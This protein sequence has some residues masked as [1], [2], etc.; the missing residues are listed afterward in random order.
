MIKYMHTLDGKPAMFDGEQIVTGCDFVD[1]VDTY[2][3]MRTQRRLA[4]AWRKR[5]GF[6][7]DR[8]DYGHQRVLV[9]P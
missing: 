3:D 5:N 9:T 4:I 8:F 1:L 6:T 2:E 7:V